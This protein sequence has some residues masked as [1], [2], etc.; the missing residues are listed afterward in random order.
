MSVYYLV[1][2]LQGHILE[3]RHVTLQLCVRC[4]SQYF[5]LRV[6]KH[7]GEVVKYLNIFLANNELECHSTISD[8]FEF[9]LLTLCQVEGIE[10]SLS[11]VHVTL[12]QQFCL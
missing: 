7:V 11:I 5:N 10:I 12:A 1:R 4:F 2:L 8:L 9:L 3:H 6:F